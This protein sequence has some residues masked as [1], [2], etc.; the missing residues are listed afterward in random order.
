MTRVKNKWSLL[1]CQD[2]NIRVTRSETMTRNM[3][4]AIWSPTGSGVDDAGG[5]IATRLAGT[6]LYNTRTE[7]RGDCYRPSSW[8]TRGQSTKL[9][10]IHFIFQVI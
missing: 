7:A 6:Y 10:A 3:T 4:A 1:G 9:Y 5:I 2:F 8:R